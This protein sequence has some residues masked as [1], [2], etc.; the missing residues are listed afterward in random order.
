MT[1]SI[2][3]PKSSALM[4]SQTVI[5]SQSLPSRPED[6]R[7]RA[8]YEEP[9]QDSPVSTIEPLGTDPL[10]QDGSNTSSGTNNNNHHNLDHRGG[11]GNNNDAASSTR[12]SSMES[13][14]HP[15]SQQQQHQ[16]HQYVYQRPPSV[17]RKACMDLQDAIALLDETCPNPDVSP[18]MTPRTPRTP[19]TPHSRN[20]RARS[21]SSDNSSNYSSER[22]NDK[23]AGQAETPRERIRPFL[24]KIGISMTEDRP[25]LAKIAPRIL[26]G[27]GKPYLEKIGHSRAVDKSFIEETNTGSSGT[28]D[29]FTFDAA[30]P[31]SRSKSSKAAAAAAK[32]ELERKMARERRDEIRGF[33]TGERR[34]SGKNFLLKMYSFETEDLVEGDNRAPAPRRDPLRG[35][36][37]DDVLESGCESTS[38]VTSRDAA[39][40]PELVRCKVTTSEEIILQLSSSSRASLNSPM[41]IASWGASPKRRAGA[42]TPCSPSKR[43]APE[44]VVA[45]YKDLDEPKQTTKTT[46]TTSSAEGTLERRKS[47]MDRWGGASSSFDN[48]S[49]RSSSC[50]RERVATPVFA[51]IGVRSTSNEANNNSKGSCSSVFSSSSITRQDQFTESYADYKL[52]TQQGQHALRRLMMSHQ[53]RQS[54][55]PPSF[56]MGF[57]SKEAALEKRTSEDSPKIR[58]KS[59][60]TDRLKDDRK[61]QQ[62]PVDNGVGS[63]SS[64]SKQQTRTKSVLRKQKRVEKANYEPDNGKKLEDDD[65]NPE[66]TGKRKLVHEPSQETLNLLQELQKVKSSLKSPGSLDEKS[67]EDGSGANDPTTTEPPL[68]AFPKRV[69][70]TDQEFCLSIERENSV[71]RP[72]PK[73]EEVV[74]ASSSTSFFEKRCLSLDYADDD[75]SSTANERRAKKSEE[76]LLLLEETSPSNVFETPT[77][78]KTTVVPAKA[79]HKKD[80]APDP[81]KDQL[82]LPKPPSNNSNS[83][84]NSN[85][86]RQQRH[87]DSDATNNNGNGNNQLSPKRRNQSES[88]SP[89]ATAFRVKKRLGRVSVEDKDKTLKQEQSFAADVNA[90]K[91][92]QQQQQQQQQTTTTTTM[93]MTTTTTTTTSTNVAAA[94][95]AVAANVVVVGGQKRAKCLPL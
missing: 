88:T 34:K 93:T 14:H 64:S 3:S 25:L 58:S 60:E 59:V 12:T 84:S 76:P 51:E 48:W 2:S 32:E 29:K 83:N 94:A 82:L 50:A 90:D 55:M 10:N 28:L 11:G 5:G 92:Q 17:P 8:W 19:L 78:E 72:A 39:A 35:A 45:V 71:R 75:K 61:K 46:A 87:S 89:K 79:K 26:G 62:Q 73:K 40:A 67:I 53:A 33:S 95:A 21:K 81:P 77:T 43:A 54:N 65:D 9:S 30:T 4:R 57:S 42:N 18:V 38:P 24:K 47:R 23:S 68:K 91:E 85:N 86:R 69:L 52:R 31:S 56:D 16:H 41:E 63:S 44:R 36:S 70:L 6:L 37:L 7:V 80:R 15:H 27:G 74:D 1:T 22:L 49:G 66:Q 20:K 13:E